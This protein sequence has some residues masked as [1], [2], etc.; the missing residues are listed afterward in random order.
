MRLKVPA[1]KSVRGVAGMLKKYVSKFAMDILPSVAATII[2]AYIV[3]HYIV[4]KPATNAPVAAAVSTA[5]PQAE[6]KVAPEAAKAGS[7]ASETSSDVANIPEAGVKAKGISERA[8]IEKTAAEKPMAVEKPAEKAADKAEKPADKPA[9]TASIAAGTR[10]HQPAPREKAVAKAVPAQV[11]PAA[12]VSAPVVAAPG[13]IPVPAVEAAIAPEE[14]RDANDLARA[15]IERLRAANDGSPRAQDAARIPDAPRVQEPPRI[16][17]APPV[18]PLPP[19]I[20]VSTP[21]AQTF[22]SPAGSSQMKPPYATRI[23][24]PRRPTPPAD[25]PAASPSSPPLDLHAEAEEPSR[26]GL[27]TVAED[28]LSAAKSVFHAV[29]PKKL[30]D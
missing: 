12:P 15:A 30:S 24:D 8:M 6:A 11:Q 28:V 22:D 9:E 4:G 26:R 13:T 19:P 25:I 3:N 16:A 21:T 1:S 29:L 23:D 20:M 10:R 17:S 5:E 2:G 7:K 18:R 27:T 14:H